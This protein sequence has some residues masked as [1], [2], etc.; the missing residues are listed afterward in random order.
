VKLAQGVGDT[1]PAMDD[2]VRKFRP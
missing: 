2:L 1:G